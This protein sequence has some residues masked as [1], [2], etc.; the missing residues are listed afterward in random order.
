[1]DTLLDPRRR[2]VWW[3]ERVR[4]WRDEKGR[5][6]PSRGRGS[7][8]VTVVLDY[9]SDK[10]GKTIEIDAF[11]QDSVRRRETPFETIER[12]RDWLFG[13]LEEY[14]GEL[15][16]WLDISDIRWEYDPY[17]KLSFD[18]D[19]KYRHRTRSGWTK[20]RHLTE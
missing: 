5:F 9:R 18:W 12:L 2:R 17:R 4:R 19:V 13:L 3:D 8:V 11:V 7:V 10:P 1:M 6:V 16:G 15:V 20:W 14:F